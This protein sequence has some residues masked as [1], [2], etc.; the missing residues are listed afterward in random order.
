MRGFS[1]FWTPC[2]PRPNLTAVP[3]N[4]LESDYV[5]SGILWSAGTLSIIVW[6]FKSKVDRW[7]SSFT[8]TTTKSERF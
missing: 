6:C 7:S 8:E 5:L 2:V 3:I 1:R 4:M